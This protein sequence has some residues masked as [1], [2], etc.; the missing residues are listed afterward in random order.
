V[1]NS[2]STP[3]VTAKAPKKRPLNLYQVRV[4]DLEW[5]DEIDDFNL[6]AAYSERQATKIVI[7]HR[8]YTERERKWITRR[9]REG[10]WDVFSRGPVPTEPGRVW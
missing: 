9:R 10:L 5:G 3:R 6:V 8:S 2:S 7:E 1:N 4:Q